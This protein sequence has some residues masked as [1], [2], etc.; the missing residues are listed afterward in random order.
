MNNKFWSGISLV[1][2]SYCQV[3]L[4][5]K[6]A[7]FLILSLFWASFMLGIILI[8]EGLTSKLQNRSLLRI[9][10]KNRKA[11]MTFILV[12]IVGGVCLEGIAQWIGKLWVYPY[13]SNWTYLA[14]FIPGFILYWLMIAESYLGV[15]AIIDRYLRSKRKVTKYYS[16]EAKLYPLLGFVGTVLIIIA[17]LI[18]RQ[19][20]ID[21][22]GYVFSIRTI[23]NININFYS[24]LS[25]FVGVWF[26]AEFYEYK[27]RETSLIKDVLHIT[28]HPYSLLYLDLCLWRCLWK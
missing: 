19:A 7:N 22:G 5:Y 4:P 3:F 18:A 2:V 24:I 25:L 12:S 20:Y 26:I 21:V 28:T 16:Y 23:E 15:K 8:G 27:R 1:L 17:L 11:K 14:V 9:V 6:N 13:F 10:Q